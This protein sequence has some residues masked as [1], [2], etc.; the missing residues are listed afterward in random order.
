M[1]YKNKFYDMEHIYSNGKYFEGGEQSFTLTLNK[2]V[3]LP[4]S[5]LH[6]D[7]EVKLKDN[8]KF[9]V[10]MGSENISYP[11]TRLEVIIRELEKIGRYQI[12]YLAN[13]INDKIDEIYRKYK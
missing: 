7:W 5:I 1:S 13:N 9:N 4:S 11:S 3:P 12:D 10:S 6:Y 2:I 8:A